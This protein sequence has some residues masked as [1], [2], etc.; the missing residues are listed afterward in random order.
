M[1]EADASAWPV[2][3]PEAIV[4]VDLVESTARTN[5]FG[6][7]AVGRGLMRELR[8]LIAQAGAARGLRCLKSTGDGYLLAYGDPQAA[9][10]A[11]VHA[12]EA[13]FALLDVTAARNQHV[14]EERA[15]HLRLAVH[16]GEVDIVENDRE[17]PHVS[18]AFRLEAISQAALP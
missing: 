12:V 16:F 4:V 11:A 17:G 10:V 9:D 8:A 5:L 2:V 3:T 1:S 15:L 14:A 18:Y 13:A 6:W 7:Y